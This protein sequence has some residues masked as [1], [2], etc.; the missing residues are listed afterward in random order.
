M[1]WFNHLLEH[2]LHQWRCSLCDGV[3]YLRLEDFK[4]H[5]HTKHRSLPDNTYSDVL[6]SCQEP[7]R[8][9]PVSNCPFCDKW[10][11]ELRK[12]QPHVP[13]PDII[14]VDWKR[15]RRHVGSHLE[16]LAL[17]AIRGCISDIHE[18]G[19]DRAVGIESDRSSLPQWENPV[20]VASSIGLSGSSQAQL[21]RT[22]DDQ[23]DTL[24]YRRADR[25][26]RTVHIPGLDK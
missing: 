8:T 5:L 21:Q 18:D 22:E 16:Q 12:I 20:S 2:H 9:I 1:A 3:P 14:L 13:D 11:C 7:L 4:Y 24:R 23:S 6:R 15:F 17:F 10:E 19:S 26:Y 25:S